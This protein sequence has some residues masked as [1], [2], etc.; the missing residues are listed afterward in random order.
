[1]FS[2]LYFLFQCGLISD[3]LRLFLQVLSHLFL[4]VTE[5]SALTQTIEE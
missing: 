2:F 3:H 1:M 5:F 4:F